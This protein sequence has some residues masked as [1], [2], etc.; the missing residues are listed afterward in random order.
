MSSPYSRRRAVLDAAITLLGTGGSRALTHRAVDEAAGVPAGTTSN[1]FRTRAALVSGVLGHLGT[2]EAEVL[3]GSAAEPAEGSHV[4]E[5]DVLAASA[6]MLAFLAGPG[7]TLALARHALMLEAARD[8]QLRPE[9]ERHTQRWWDIAAR[10]LAGAGAADPR[11][12]GRTLL[13]CLDGLLVD[14]LARPDPDFDPVSSLTPVVR[15]LLG[16]RGR[17]SARL[18]TSPSGAPDTPIAQESGAAPG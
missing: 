14:Q 17:A 8:E 10:R 9:L 12:A 11:R 6:A 18:T 2:A 7:R 5:A 16:D 4:G 1:H 15:G 3:A 13:A